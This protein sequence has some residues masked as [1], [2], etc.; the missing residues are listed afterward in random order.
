[1]LVNAKFESV[2][3]TQLLFSFFHLLDICCP[4]NLARFSE[5][6]RVKSPFELEDVQGSLRENARL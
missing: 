2:A 5:I 1:M 6:G 3:L 4:L